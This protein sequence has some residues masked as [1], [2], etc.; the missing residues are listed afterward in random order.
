MLRNLGGSIGI[1]LLATRLDTGDAVHRAR[2]AEPVSIYQN[3]TVERLAALAGHFTLAGADP[4]TAAIRGLRVLDLTLHRE[5][6]VA[7]YGDA[8][9]LLGWVLLG[10]LPFALL[11]VKKPGIL[12]S[13]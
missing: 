11:P 1:A 13:D 9:T 12:P 10:S 4:H 5:A 8:F 6:R 7:A 3:A 2:L